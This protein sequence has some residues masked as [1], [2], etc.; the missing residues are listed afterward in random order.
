MVVGVY[1]LDKEIIL[2]LIA[3]HLTITCR[4]YCMGI[5]KGKNIF[6]NKGMPFLCIDRSQSRQFPLDICGCECG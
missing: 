3:D 1:I 4:P 2:D 5:S 6:K